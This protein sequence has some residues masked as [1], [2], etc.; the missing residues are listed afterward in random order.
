M[1][2]SSHQRAPASPPSSISGGLAATLVLVSTLWPLPTSAE[3][4]CDRW[5]PVNPLPIETDLN[6]VASSDGVYLVVG[7]DGVMLASTDEVSWRL[8]DGGVEEDLNAVAGSPEGFVVVGDGGTILVGTPDG[9]WTPA[10][11]GTDQDLFDVVGD[12]IDSL[13]A[14]GSGGTILHSSDGGGS[15]SDRGPGGPHGIL[16]AT[17]TGR[18]FVAVGDGGSILTSETGTSWSPIDLDVEA[19]FHTVA[20]NDSRTIAIA[21]DG[22]IAIVTGDDARVSGLHHPEVSD[23]VWYNDRFLSAGSLRFS[24]DGEIWHP[25]EATGLGPGT[26]AIGPSW[27]GPGDPPAAIVVGSG[28]TIG[29]SA[30]NAEHW[31]PS[32]TLTGVKLH[33]LAATDDRAVAV[34][35]DGSRFASGFHGAIL[36]SADLDHW[37]VAM[38]S[39]YAFT[40]VAANSDTFM[41][42]GI[43]DSAFGSWGIIRTSTDGRNWED[44]IQSLTG[45]PGWPPTPLLRAISWDGGR[46]ISA[47][48][49]PSV[50]V[51]PDG[52]NWH[53][54]TSDAQAY[55][56]FRGVASDG[57]VIVAV[58][59]GGGWFGSGMIGLSRD[60]STLEV[61]EPPNLEPLLDVAWGD[62][63]FVAVG[64]GGTILTSPDGLSWTPRPSGVASDLVRVRWDGEGFTAMG[65]DGVALVSPDGVV[66]LPLDLGTE[67]D[68]TD[69]LASTMGHVV[70]GDHGLL[71]RPDCSSPDD[72][73][74]ASFSWRPSNPEAGT[75]VRFFDLST[76]DPTGWTW[77]FGDGITA[78][79]P[80]ATHVFAEHGDWPVSLRAENTAGSDTASAAVSVRRFCGA[81]PRM[82]LDAPTS[83]ASG[84]PYTVSW[85]PVLA[86]WEEGG[87][88]LTERRTPSL[89]DP[90]DW[91]LYVESTSVER[92]HTW[93]EGGVLFTRGRA[94]NRCPD[95]TYV[96]ELSDLVQT[97][98]VPEL[99]DLGEHL[100]TIPAAATSGG[101]GGTSWVTDVAIHNP[102]EDDAP[103]YLVHLP[104]VGE[105]DAALSRRLSVPAGATLSLEDAMAEF[106]TD[107]TGALL[108]TSDRS[109]Q[110]TSRTYNDQPD[111]TFG[112]F[113][114]G[115]PIAGAITGDR[116]GTMIQLTQNTDTRAN[117]A[118]ANPL[119]EDVIVD[120]EAYTAAGESIGTA[121]FTVPG[122]GSVFEPRFL[123]R[124]TGSLVEDAYAVARPASQQGAVI[125]LASVVDDRTGDPTTQS[126]HDGRIR[127]RGVVIGR[128]PAIS[129]GSYNGLVYA[130][131]RWVFAGSDGV[132][133]S[134]DGVVW[135]R[136]SG[137]PA[138][139]IEF[140]GSRILAF[141]CH[142]VLIS[143]DGETWERNPTPEICPQSMC[144]DGVQWFGV[145]TN[146]SAILTSLDGIEWREDDIEGALLYSVVR[147]GDRY[148]GGANGGVARSLDGRVWQTVDLGGSMT[149]IEWNGTQYLAWN[150]RELATS[151]DG[152]TWTVQDPDLDLGDAAWAGDRWVAGVGSPQWRTHSAYMVSADGETWEIVRLPG[153]SRARPMTVAWNGELV[154]GIDYFDNLSLLVGDT[155]TVA[156]PA[157]AHVDGFGGARWRSDL[158]LHNPHEEPVLCTIELLERDAANHD[159]DSSVVSVGE[160]Q[161]I[162]LVD[163]VDDTFDTEGAGALRITP[164]QH[165]VMVSSR[166]YDD[167]GEGTYGQQVPGL[168]GVDAVWHFEEG[169]LIGLAHS[170]NRSSGFRTNIGL[171]SACARP[172]DIEIELFDG[173]GRPLGTTHTLLQA[174]GVHQLNDVFRQMTDEV[175]TNGRAV[176]R[177]PTAQCSFYAYASVVD[178]GTNDPTLIP[179]AH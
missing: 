149:R 89:D 60:G 116:T 101:F 126:A 81:P 95:G 100:W 150:L 8:I 133:V 87:H 127:N 168:R 106:G 71:L 59:Q 169:R 152:L 41:V 65:D 45:E 117:L 46:W 128:T 159:P 105:G 55:G 50:L 167:S 28:G 113:V 93:T 69:I 66:W 109:L 47:G 30:D 118:L 26:T 48:S 57:A 179:V 13:V 85:D 138:R 146:G 35:S 51:S 115:T 24:F 160:K 27:L 175:V 112:Q 122:L 56:D 39:G 90:Y 16:G 174:N 67:N 15:W 107:A 75:P 103:A 25:S 98:V 141:G 40:D 157:A 54:L 136:I 99:T 91:D 119:P 125:A 62:G 170:P 154:L 153:I 178:N 155:P 129:H 104:R 11:S 52:A 77:D 12:G 92:T 165:G 72:P 110:A 145:S 140:N 37:E 78:T 31:K 38:R 32:N 137:F 143:D 14:V 29:H 4:P 6:G 44:A 147:G 7:D 63:R 111:G 58:G 1:N 88:A 74:A 19:D 94:I 17:W 171:V 172:M 164:D 2:P 42:T 22:T 120:V 162:R 132:S 5:R 177:T 121:S 34:A 73:P 80:A 151:T 102:D 144:W 176:V 86:P 166:T 131:D 23:L 84:Q 163:V 108:V 124:F 148:V 123:R 3:L 173:E 61:T 49:G 114:D 36:L 18:S 83:V 139:G 43:G 76:G 97:D 53:R 20:G 156:I 21:T 70:G 135:E 96:S 82:T 134:G 64:D 10:S 79:S 158:E 161:S 130:H 33:G 9:G 142:E 68:L